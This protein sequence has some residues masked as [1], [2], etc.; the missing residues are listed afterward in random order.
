MVLCLSDIEQTLMGTICDATS[1]TTNLNWKSFVKLFERML[2][3]LFTYFKLTIER[4][5]FERLH[6]QNIVYVACTVRIY[7]SCIFFIF[8]FLTWTYCVSVEKSSWMGIKKLFLFHKSLNRF[9]R[10]YS[11]REVKEPHLG[12]HPN[13]DHTLDV[14]IKKIPAEF[15]TPTSPLWRIKS[16]MYSGLGGIFYNGPLRN[17]WYLSYVSHSRNL[18]I[19]S[20]F[21]KIIGAVL[22]SQQHNMFFLDLLPQP[23]E[24]IGK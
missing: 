13:L 22:F 21:F 15:Q 9:K 19:Y 11:M 3:W 4:Q 7:C 10:D 1:N 20:N 24:V 12:F 8:Y 23:S 14:S 6:Q 2:L 17:L 16:K 18:P 5:T